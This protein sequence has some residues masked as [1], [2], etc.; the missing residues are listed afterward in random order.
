MKV[1]KI[2]NS[3]LAFVVDGKVVSCIQ[4]GQ[5]RADTAKLAYLQNLLA[6]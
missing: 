1:V 3:T 2:T 5:F 4:N 6:R